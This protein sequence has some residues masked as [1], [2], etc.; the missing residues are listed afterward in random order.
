MLYENRLLYVI[1]SSLNKS[2]G[3]V[4]AAPALTKDQNRSAVKKVQQRQDIINKNQRA[5]VA[6]RDAI[7][8]TKNGLSA[9]NLGTTKQDYNNGKMPLRVT[10]TK[11]GQ[12]KTLYAS[13]EQKRSA[14]RMRK[15]SEV[16]KKHSKAYNDLI[17]NGGWMSQEE[18]QDRMD[19]ELSVLSSTFE[20][21][22][23]YN[24]QVADKKKEQ[25]GKIKKVNTI[26]GAGAIR[27]S[28]TTVPII[29]LNNVTTAQ[30]TAMSAT[31]GDLVVTWSGKF[32]TS[33]G[34]N[35]T[36]MLSCSVDKASPSGF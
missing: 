19:S 13:S 1:L 27:G 20:A 28:S 3:S 9:K 7:N 12:A 6:E 31:N 16:K 23:Q 32:N 8:S 35:T 22:D 29:R 11:T 15:E 5:R 18:Y 4:G 34:G 14:D 26:T 17:A 24:A 25:R 30:R 33:N 36:A 10:N 21:N 2:R